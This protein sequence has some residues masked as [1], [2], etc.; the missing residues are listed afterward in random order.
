MKKL[1]TLLLFLFASIQ[2]FAQDKILDYY[3]K[4][5]SY[6]E[7]YLQ[8]NFDYRGDGL[9]YEKTFN[10][11][12]IFFLY[13]T[14]YKRV[15]SIMIPYTSKEEVKIYEDFFNSINKTKYLK[16]YWLIRTDKSNLLIQ[17]YN[18]KNNRMFIAF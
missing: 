15:I 17:I 18:D 14:E 13:S 2:I 6:C 5:L 10:N 12:K 16:K 3:A 4:D 8:R 9:L 1:I 7:K 11:T